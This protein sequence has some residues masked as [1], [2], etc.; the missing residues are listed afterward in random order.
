M[1]MIKICE[2]YAIEHNICF[3]GKMSKSLFFDKDGKYKYNHTITVNNEVVE[4]CEVVDHLG[5]PIHTGK[6][7]E[8][9][10]EIG[11]NNLNAMFYSFMSRF[12]DCFPTTRNKLFHQYCSSMYGSQLWLMNSNSVEKDISRWCK[13]HRIVLGVSNPTL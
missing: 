3:N 6:T 7:L 1:N 12:R 13:Y 2:D 8:T 11:L 9:L 5:H 10:A 4:R